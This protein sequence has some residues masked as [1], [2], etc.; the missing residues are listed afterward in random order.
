MSQTQVLSLNTPAISTVN[1]GQANTENGITVFEEVILQILSFGGV[2][3]QPLQIREC[4]EILFS[5]YF[6]FSLAELKFF[7]LKVKQGDT[8]MFKCLDEY[9]GITPVK[10]LQC[11]REYSF[12]C[13]D[14]RE[15]QDFLNKRDALVAEPTHDENGNPIV[16]ADPAEITKTML[17]FAGV[18]QAE[19]EAGHA[20]VSDDVLKAKEALQESQQ[21]AALEVFA[22]MLAAGGEICDEG[23][24]RFYMLNRVAIDGIVEQLKQSA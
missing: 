3:W 9:G 7:A 2:K 16:W 5:E 23:D 10:M 17:E 11:A 13:L 4:A 1:V 22:G 14:A 15:S 12:K 6:W 8:N 24:M 20:Q 21:M 18:F 19:A